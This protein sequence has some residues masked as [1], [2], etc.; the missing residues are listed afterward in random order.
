MGFFLKNFRSLKRSIGQKSPK[1]LDVVL[2]DIQALINKKILRKE[3]NR[4]VD[5]GPG[6]NSGNN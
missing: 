1:A 4:V 6:M 5:D 2:R 3:K